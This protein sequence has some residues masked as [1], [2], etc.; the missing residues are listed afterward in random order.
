MSKKRYINTRFWDDNYIVNLDP[1]EKLLFIYFLTNPLT[2]ICGIYEIPLRRIAFDTG[3]DKDMVFKIIERFTEDE[4]IFYLNNSWIYIKNFAKHQVVNDSVKKG[5]ERSRLEVP[6]EILRIIEEF[7]QTATDCDSLSPD[8]DL[9][10]LKPRLKLKPRLRLKLKEREAIA[11]PSQIANKFFNELKEQERIL[12]ILKEKGFNEEIARREVYKFINYWTELNKSGSK[13]RWETEKT[14]EVG[15][16]LSTWFSRVRE[17]SNQN[18][19][20]KEIII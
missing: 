11:S 15:K 1:I 16:R 6:E 13:K 7:E 14:F 19:R 9:L 3:I 20:G 17:F 8:C 12:E 5:I 4:K 10:R 18:S 2:D